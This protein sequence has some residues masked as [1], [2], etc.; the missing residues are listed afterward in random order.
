MTLTEISDQVL[1]PLLGHGQ[2]EKPNVSQ[3]ER[4]VSIAVGTV[5][6]ML[7]ITRLSLPGLL[8]AGVG[9]ALI[10]RG[11]TGYCPAYAKMN[12]DTAD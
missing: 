10:R 12:V 6:A 3:N 1:T 8:I 5:L 2:H 4:T 9:A 7:G 11:A